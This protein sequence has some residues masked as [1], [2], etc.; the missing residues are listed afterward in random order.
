MHMFFFLWN[1]VY[2]L[3]TSSR[4]L[5]NN[6]WLIWNEKGIGSNLIISAIIRDFSHLDVLTMQNDRLIVDA[7]V[8][9]CVSQNASSDRLV[10]LVGRSSSFLPAKS[11]SNGQTKSAKQAGAATKSKLGGAGP[12]LGSTRAASAGAHDSG[13]NSTNSSNLTT[14]EGSDVACTE[15][16]CNHH[17]GQSDRIFSTNPA[18][19]VVWFLFN[20]N[21]ANFIG[22]IGFTMGGSD[23]VVHVKNCCWNFK[24]CT[25]NVF[26]VQLKH[27]LGKILKQ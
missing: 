11:S 7:T 1:F 26:S 19:L 8:V 27:F 21:N 23:S 15:G 24:L 18:H 20:D 25:F 6:P 14:P 16:L 10:W 22:G 12:K 4:L 5:S 3:L 13:Y 9:V 17:S 2:T